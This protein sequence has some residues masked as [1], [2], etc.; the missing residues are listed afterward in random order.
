MA[1]LMVPQ[2]GC[3]NRIVDYISDRGGEVA[4]CAAEGD[5]STLMAQLRGSFGAE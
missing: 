1:F 4:E 3:V 5:R 2:S